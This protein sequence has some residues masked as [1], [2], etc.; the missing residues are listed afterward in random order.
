MGLFNKK[1]KTI[2]IQATEGKN[3][4]LEI[5]SLMKAHSLNVSMPGMKNTYASYQ[6]QVE[7]TYRKYN[8]LS[9]FGSQQTRATIDIRSAFI[10]GE[11][12]SVSCKN[13]S[14][15]R[16]IK[17]F[18]QTQKLNGSVF[19]NAVKSSEMV[20]QVLFALEYM[21]ESETK[22]GYV[23]VRRLKYTS[24]TPFKVK[25]SDNLFSD[26]IESIAIRKGGFW[27]PLPLKN[28]VYIR[29]GGDDSNRYEP[30]TKVGVVLTDIDN[31]DR[32]LKDIR[33]NNFIFARVTPTFEVSSEAEA[34]NLKSWLQK[35]HW[36]IGTAFIGKAKFK[37]ESP[38]TSAFQ[39]LES[40]LSSTIKTISATTGIPV[41][42][43][44]FVDLMS[45]RATATSLYEMV[46]NATI[47]E[48][49]I[50][51]EAVYD[52]ILK[53]QELYIDNGGV[54]LDF[55][56]DFEVKI[57]LINYG[58]FLERVKALSQAY[59]DEAIS[60]D[61]YRNQLPGIDPLSTEKAVNKE[62]EKG[63]QDLIKKGVLLDKYKEKENDYGE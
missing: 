48:R 37:Y 63:E 2:T 22:E 13:E 12:V 27:K 55:D 36:K 9:D 33:R 61:D 47:S 39:N 35:V 28:Y 14:T 53:A 54:G 19:L 51:Q 16:W 6:A 38:G 11:G 43:L 40:E 52:L 1:I 49:T 60:I 32:A 15:S 30:T 17:N 10:S 44:G 31:Y 62:K 41:H 7:E 50:W 20:G 21:K 23:K 4:P 59:A 18:L 29:T 45:N 5:D 58:D 25:Y 56:R 42:W 34:K 24:E 3:G 57:P 46:K 26:E 8:A